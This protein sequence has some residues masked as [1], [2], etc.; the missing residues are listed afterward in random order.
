MRGQVTDQQKPFDLS[1]ASPSAKLIGGWVEDLIKVATEKL[2]RDGT[3]ASNQLSQSIK[4]VPI[5]LR[6]DTLTIG[7]EMNGYWKFVDL[8]VKGAKS[9]AKAPASPFQYRQK[10][11]PPRAIQEWIAFKGIPLM[12]NDKQAANRALSFHIAKRIRDFGTKPT[13]FFSD[14]LTPDKINV[15]AEDIAAAI[16]KQIGVALQL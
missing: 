9:S 13:R 2:Q 3:N 10:M 11:P 6:E 7:I 12:G 15:L 8:G 16:G 4:L 5:D 1:K 14:S